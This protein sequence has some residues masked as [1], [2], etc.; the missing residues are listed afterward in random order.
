ML[1]AIAS[2]STTGQAARQD[3]SQIPT[4]TSTIGVGNED[5]E[6]GLLSV[7]LP[8]RPGSGF[9]HQARTNS[10]IHCIATEL[11]LQTH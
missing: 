9:R 5:D 3:T 1:P 8:R 6:Q 10:T 11:G 2:T 7:E 4:R